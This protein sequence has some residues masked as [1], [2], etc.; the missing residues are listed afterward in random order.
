MHAYIGV[1][2]HPYFAVS[3]ADGS[4]EITNIPPGDYEIEAWHEILGTQHEKITITPSG[5]IETQFSFKG[6]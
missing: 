3:G 5:H 4:F 6:E 1:L 2:D